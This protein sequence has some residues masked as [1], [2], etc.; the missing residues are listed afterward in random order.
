MFGRWLRQ[1]K[2]SQWLLP[3]FLIDACLGDGVGVETK[4]ALAISIINLAMSIL[5]HLQFV[6]LHFHFSILLDQFLH[7]SNGD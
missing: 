5:S 2:P 7:I 1:L 4:I 6:N 3:N